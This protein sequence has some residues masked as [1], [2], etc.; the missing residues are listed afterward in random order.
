MRREWRLHEILLTASCYKGRQAAVIW[1]S[2]QL[3][4]VQQGSLILFAPSGDTESCLYCSCKFSSQLQL[5][6][7]TTQATDWL[8]RRRLNQTI[9][10]RG[11]RDNSCSLRPVLTVPKLINTANCFVLKFFPFPHETVNLVSRLWFHPLHRLALFGVWSIL[12]FQY[13]ICATSAGEP[14]EC[15]KC[16]NDFEVNSVIRGHCRNNEPRSLLKYYPTM[17]SLSSLLRNDDV[18]HRCN[19]IPTMCGKER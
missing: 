15:N 10:N 9:L 6:R 12:K 13:V 14:R 4:R 5:K 8:Q 17:T 19:T 7:G 18:S 16:N 3:A 2:S 11:L 1:R